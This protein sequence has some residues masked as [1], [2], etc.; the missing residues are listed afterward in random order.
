[1]AQAMQT[2]TIPVVRLTHNTI[3]KKIYKHNNQGWI[4]LQLQKLLGGEAKEQLK[5]SF[6]PLLPMEENRSEWRS[7]LKRQQQMPYESF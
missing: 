1:M 7:C 5:L 6:H 3:Y 4:P 2:R